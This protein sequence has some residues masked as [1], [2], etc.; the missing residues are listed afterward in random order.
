MNRS[1]LIAEKLKALLEFAQDG[2][3]IDST[4]G[5]TFIDCVIE[6]YGCRLNITLENGLEI[7]LEVHLQGM[8]EVP[9]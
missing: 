6:R 7:H 5:N 4:L 8:Q 2:L 1:E 9:R 3:V